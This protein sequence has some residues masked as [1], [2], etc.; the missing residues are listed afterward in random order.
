MSS[1]TIQPNEAAVLVVDDNPLIVNVL[2]GLLASEN[3]QVYVSNN[4]VEALEVL[5]KKDIDV[6]ICDVMMPQMDG[7]ELHQKMRENAERAHIPFVFLTAL[8]DTAEITKGREIGADDY[9]VKPFDPR[10]LLALVK[11]KI[12]RSRNIKNSSQE[13]Y[14]TFRKKIIHT[15][16]HEFRT[17][18]VAINTGTELLIEQK[19]AIDDKKIQNLLEAIRRGGQRLERLVSDFML[20]Q[21]IEAGM[22]QKLFDT[23]AKKV[24][25]SD[26][27]SEFLQEQADYLAAEKFQVVYENLD[28]TAEI[29]VYVP[30]VK[31]ILFRFVNNCIKFKRKDYII[32]IQLYSQEKEIIIEVRD[33]GLG[34]DVDKVKE[35]VDIF[36]QIDR[37][38]LE[39][40]G[41]GLGLAIASRY[42][43]I[44]HGR[45]E[46][47]NRE[48][49]GAIVSLIIPKAPVIN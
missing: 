42:A 6:V 33:R 15:L 38:R 32:E 37:E 11:G 23:R 7:Y 22:A 17:P 10:Q 31:D 8:S 26:L 41:S 25:A 14:D 19:E 27:V 20:L 1:E 28:A 3:Y 5:G 13:K 43:F 29:Y 12:Q 48:G 47:E 40:Q 18:L 49:G 16:S 44:N 35:A 45:I 4:G 30:Q 21:Q 39:Q 24:L 34:I 9:L 36:G 2:K 46:F